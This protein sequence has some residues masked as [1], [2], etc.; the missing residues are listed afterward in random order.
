M[1]DVLST[2]SGSALVSLGCLQGALDWASL[3]KC[4]IP[5]NKIVVVSTCIC[6]PLARNTSWSGPSLAKAGGTRRQAQV[7]AWLQ[8]PA[9]A[10]VGASGGVLGA[11]HLSSLVFLAGGPL[12][13]SL[14][15]ILPRGSAQAES[16]ILALAQKMTTLGGRHGL[17][18]VYRF[19]RVAS[20]TSTFSRGPHSFAGTLSMDSAQAALSVLVACPYHGFETN[21]KQPGLRISLTA[22][23][24]KKGHRS[25]LKIVDTLCQICT[26]K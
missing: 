16:M 13:P 23:L 26:A 11:A 5:P 10:T 21:H 14:S 4:E 15:E 19:V 25:P 3:A 7:A 24:T 22:Q 12:F 18:Y 6:T 8:V 9:L 17:Y 2:E 1:K 20:C